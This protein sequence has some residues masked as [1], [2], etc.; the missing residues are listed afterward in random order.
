MRLDIIERET[1]WRAKVAANVTGFLPGPVAVINYRKEF[2]G[3]YYSSGM[4]KFLS[5]REWN[6][7]EVALFVTFVSDLN[8]CKF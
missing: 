3:Q 5:F 1:P 8:K 6:E 4:R 2:F 7:G